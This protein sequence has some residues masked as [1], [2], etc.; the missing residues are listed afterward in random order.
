VDEEP[1]SHLTEEPQAERGAMGSRDK[2]GPPGAGP[3]DRPAG[4]SDTDDSTGVDPQEPQDD[5]P[6]LPAGDQGG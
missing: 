4:T 3:A 2:G 1:G 5:L 6:T